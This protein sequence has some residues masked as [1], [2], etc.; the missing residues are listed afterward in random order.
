MCDLDYL[1]FKLDG[2]LAVIDKSG[3]D[4]V[5]GYK[6]LSKNSEICNWYLY[7]WQVLCGI[8]P[9]LVCYGHSTGSYALWSW[10]EESLNNDTELVNLNA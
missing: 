7:D 10:N 9:C 8:S 6:I 2:T 4:C 3:Y 1:S 5:F